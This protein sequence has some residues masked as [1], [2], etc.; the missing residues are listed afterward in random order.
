MSTS[1]KYFGN[2][3]YKISQD[4][5]T[6]L[7]NSVNLLIQFSGQIALVQYRGFKN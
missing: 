2:E 7:I 3:I 4:E 5:N 1:I 6:F